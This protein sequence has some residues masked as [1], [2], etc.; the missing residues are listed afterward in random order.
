MSNPE[1]NELLGQFYKFISKDTPY[2]IFLASIHSFLRNWNVT[3]TWK[4][5]RY[6][7]FFFHTLT[8]AYFGVVHNTDI[9]SKIEVL[10]TLYWTERCLY[11]SRIFIFVVPGET[12]EIISLRCVDM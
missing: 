11:F 5:M 2:C 4:Q 6:T 8:H 12:E 10:F 1:D 7:Y 3:E 9:L